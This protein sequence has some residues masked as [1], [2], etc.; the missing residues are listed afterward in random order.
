[1]IV[2]VSYLTRELPSDASDSDGLIT[3]AIIEAGQ[4]VNTWAKQYEQWPDYT[5]NGGGS[6]TINAPRE[7]SRI[8]TQIAKLLYY[9]AIGRVDRDGLEDERNDKRMEGY[10]VLL[11]EIE[12]SPTVYN[13]TINLNSDGTQLIARN[14]KILRY[15]P[16]CRIES[17]TSP[18]NI[19]YQGQDWDIRQGGTFDSEYADGWYLDS[20]G[21]DDL[22]EG[23][24]YYARSWRNDNKDYIRFW[25]AIQA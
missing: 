24:L 12:V 17:H 11:G 6:Y 22:I 18:A 9:Q 7:I 2:P 5:D 1:M 14:Q 21:N 10:K 19:T 20:L 16:L 4:F 25:R 8:C 15:H 13:L 23:T 3:G